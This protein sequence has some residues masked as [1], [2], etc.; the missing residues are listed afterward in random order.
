MI[1]SRYTFSKY[2]V[3]INCAAVLFIWLLSSSVACYAQPVNIKFTH[4]KNTDGLSQSTVNSIIKD[5]YGFMWFGTEDGL[6]RYDGYKFKVYRNSPNDKKSIRSNYIQ[7]I[8]EDKSGNI[9]VGTLGSLCLYN[10]KSDSFSTFEVDEKDPTSMSNKSV[11]SI[12]EDK[13]DNLWVGT[14]WNLNLV[15]R[16]TKKVKR[17]ASVENDPTTLSSNSILSIAEDSKNNLW[18]GTMNGLNL[19]DRKTGKVKRYLP[20]PADSKS[21]ASSFVKTILED[22]KGNLWIGTEKGL[23]LFD[24]KSGVFTHYQNNPKDPSSISSDFVTTI[25]QGENGNLWVGNQEAVEIFNPSTGKF[26]HLKNKIGDETSLTTNSIQKI[27]NDGKGIIW[28]GTYNGGINKYDK[29]LTIFDVIRYDPLS[30]NSLSGNVVTSFCENNDG[31]IWVGTDGNGLNLVDRNANVITRIMSKPN[32]TNDFQNASVITLFKANLSNKLWIGH[33]NAGL[34]SFDEKTKVYRSYTIAD[35]AQGNSVYSV[36][37]GRDGKVW[38]GTNGGGIYT[39]NQVTG[40]LINHAYN[41]ATSSIDSLNNNYIRALHEDREGNIWVGTFSGGINVYHPETNKFSHLDKATSGLGSDII[42]SIIEDKKNRIWVGTMGGGLNLY[43]PKTR[44]FTSFTEKDGLSNNI[45]NSIVEDSKGNLWLSSNNGI[46]RFNPDTKAVRIFSSYNG[47][48]STEFKIGSGYISKAGEVFFGGAN[49]FNVFSPSLIADNKNAPVVRFTDFQLFN[50]SLSIGGADSVLKQDISL[51]KEIHLTYKQNVFTFGFSALSY[52]TPEQNQYAY[53]L[54]EFDQQWNY[55][56]NDRKASYTNLDPGEYTFLV[57]AANNDGL[58]NDQPTS[59]KIIITP[60]FWLTWWFK[61]FAVL[62]IVTAAYSF[63]RMRINAVNAQKDLLEKQ[64]QLRTF[65]VV[66]QAEELKSQ[67]ENLQSLNEELQTQSEELKDQKEQE[68]QARQ[69]AEEAR[70][71]A[72][73]A[74]QAKST[75]LATM[76]HEIRTP[77]NGVIGMASLLADTKLN[78]EQSEYVS[79][80]T[81]S[82][83]ALLGV[84]NDIL[85]FSKIESGNM[86]IEQHDFDLRECIEGVMDLFSTKAADQGLDLV[87]QID[88]RIPIMIVGD[89]FRLRQILINLVNNALKFTHQGEVFVKVNMVNATKDSLELSFDIKDTG[90][91][92]PEDKLTRLF[93]AFSQ[94]D[95]STTRKYG[96]TGLGLAIS[97]RLVKLMQG[98]IWVNSVVGEGATFSF[99]IKSRVGKNDQRQYASFSSLGN[100][101]KKILIVDDNQTNLTILKTQLELWKLNV[102]EAASGEIAL[103]I[104]KTDQ[105]FSLIITDMQ[106]PDMD[107]IMLTKRLKEIKPTVPVILLSSV[108]DESRSKFPELFA[109]LL[110]KPVKQTQLYKIIQLQLK[111]KDKEVVQVVEEKS[112]TVLN[113]NFAE[114]S[115]L[116]ILLAEDN[117]INQKLAIRILNK[118]GYDPDLANNGREAIDRLAAK[119]YDLILMDILMPEMDGLE[120]TRTIR[121]NSAH[122]PQIVAMTANAMPEDREACLSAGMDDYITKPIK[123]EILMEV[124]KKVAKT[125]VV[126]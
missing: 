83:D 45:I 14:S 15:D 112:T 107:G 105:D 7:A 78:E 57:K 41:A 48:Q 17:F 93:K 74:N 91:G 55:I 104:F 34:S 61:T 10:R 98:E 96:G 8:Y 19:L 115:P 108:G 6:N 120:A 72:E 31:K 122:Q 38:V 124:L 117:L 70:K 123:F 116:Q 80:I 29:N 25:A 69:E 54:Q 81:T 22:K 53:K 125:V 9:W 43:N 46:S 126:K 121:I 50:K 32:S 16:K 66:Q 23:E 92:I 36:M 86:E 75:F 24:P 5:K 62:S 85:D 28:I 13:Q 56:G 2:I 94:V 51:T 113:E 52:T 20:N 49:G 27:Y 95:S 114:T 97:E 58:W 12:F 110:T 106:M 101:G 99:S 109:S 64:V 103:D 63:Y 102:V 100:E 3:T 21:L 40:A 33:Y 111:E 90:I 1:V 30:D 26:A 44:K 35:N 73:R 89:S 39:L 37:E 60:P 71:D 18:V 65:E 119:N 79:I 118:L 87:Y 82:G 77:M 4:L 84:I 47:L 11:T 76:S 42:F 88:H 68:H 67:S 59:I